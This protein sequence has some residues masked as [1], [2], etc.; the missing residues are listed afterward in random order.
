MEAQFLQGRPA[1]GSTGRPTS[2]R[3]LSALSNSTPSAPRS[4]DIQIS[5]G[6]NQVSPSPQQLQAGNNPGPAPA[7]GPA[8]M[9]SAAGAREMNKQQSQGLGS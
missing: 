2:R 8:Q 1:P 4:Y 3:Q 7:S 5:P 6:Q 9:V